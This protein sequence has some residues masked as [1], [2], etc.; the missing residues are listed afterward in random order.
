MLQLLQGLA[1][2][3]ALLDLLHSIMLANSGIQMGDK[4]Y[5]IDDRGDFR[6]THKNT[7][8]FRKGEKNTGSK[9]T[10]LS[11]SLPPSL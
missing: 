7:Y 11:L 8:A 4:M 6:H 3:C 2:I 10:D 5:G 1:D 9:N